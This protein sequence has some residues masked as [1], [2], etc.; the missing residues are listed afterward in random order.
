MTGQTISH[1]ELAEKIGEGGMGVV[2][3]AR[4][5]HLDR[6]VALKTLPAPF[7]ADESRRTRFLREARA[8]SALNHAH[9]ITIHDFVDAGGSYFLV[10]EYIEGK[11]LDCLIPRKG[12]RLP[13]L[14]RIAIPAA[15]A[16]AAAHKAGIVHRDVKPGN[17]LVPNHGNVKILDF[18]L[19]KRIDETPAG[20]GETTRTWLQ[21][22]EEGVVIGTVAYMSPEQ[23]QG[24]PV[25]A[26]SD[27]F[28]FGAMLYEMATGER[29]FRGDSKLSTLSAVLKDEPKPA[30]EMPRELAKIISRCLRKDPERRLQSMADLRLALEE[31][32]EESES[33]ALLVQPAAASHRTTRIAWLAIS[34]IAAII[35]SGLW[36]WKRNQ[37]EPAAQPV[38][39]SPKPL[40]AYAGSETGPTLSPD[41]NQVAFSW[42]GETQEN[43]DIYVR[44][45][46]GGAPLRLTTD[47][48]RDIAPAWSPDGASIAFLRIR[49]DATAAVYLV[50]PLGGAEREIGEA[51]FDLLLGS[52]ISWTPD[53]KRVIIARQP[54]GE[55]RP[56]LFTLD[57][58]SL[59]IKPLIPRTPDVYSDT[60]LTYSPDGRS[61]AFI[62]FRGANTQEL[63]IA[64]GGG[65][66]K[67]LNRRE[68]LFGGLTWTPDSEEIVYSTPTEIQRL[69]VDKAGTAPRTVAAIAGVRGL[70]LSRSGRLVYSVNS[71]DQNLYVLDVDRA[72]SP[73]RIIASST[74][75]ESH[76]QISPDGSRIAFA[77]YRSGTQEIWI[78]GIDGSPPT[79]LTTLGGLA[80]SPAW[81]SDGKRIA[82]SCLKSRNR[83]IYVVNANGAGLH[84]LTDDAFEQG[85]PMWSRDGL[86]VYYYSLRGG[87]SEIWRQPVE[88]G[89][90]V[91]VTRNTGH[92]AWESADAASLFIEKFQTPG[93]F[94][95]RLDG[96]GET[97]LL[98]DALYGG[99]SLSRDGIFYVPRGDVLPLSMLFH[100]LRTGASR[101]VGRIEKA[102]SRG[103]NYISASWD[104]KR[105]VWSQIDSSTADLMLVENFQ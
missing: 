48:A 63:Y 64:A 84:R 98:P 21:E 43:V 42:N 66:P 79:Q 102:V 41:G 24:K 14:L 11:S 56:S 93:L 76:P 46:A 90:A 3:K 16:L 69:R 101:R 54:E 105:L 99:C 13:E 30:A 104:G 29:A 83:D 33:G 34:V 89:Q 67:P 7:V 53:S 95:A 55:P 61:F 73:A 100:D 52:S 36:L 8:A 22:T 44:L 51:F 5:I 26:R 4:D 74:L 78:A 9:I 31:L 77:S 81:S 87:R 6:W 47:M 86:S 58:Q 103:N 17:I 40:T 97:M 94:R 82:F 62:R 37:P 39:F 91:Q 23:A 85:R 65:E 10:M 27:I 15:D 35:A 92:R 32:K 1:Y 18:G 59:E 2:W 70:N 50:S 71:V 68:V 60:Q 96:S 49:R 72:G 12:L 28:S 57:V 25:D 88:G 45:I 19:A 75:P 20:E 38:A 80:H